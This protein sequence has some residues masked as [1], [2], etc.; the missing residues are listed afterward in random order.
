MLQLMRRAW[1]SLTPE[2]ERELPS[3]IAILR[4]E[5][6]PSKAEIA[7]EIARA[8]RLVQHGNPRAWA[9]WLTEARGL[10]RRGD[11]AADPLVATAAKRTMAVID[12]HDALALGL[13]RRERG[14]K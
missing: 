3:L 14:T 12:N 10:A 7:A 8:E 11:R 2:P 4:C 6:E 9:R 13:A 5:G 1:L